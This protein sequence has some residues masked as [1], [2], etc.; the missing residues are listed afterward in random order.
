MSALNTSHV[1]ALW[2]GQHKG[3]EVD[4]GL[5]ACPTW[6]GVIPWGTIRMSWGTHHQRSIISISWR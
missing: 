2:Q 3:P 5:V 6:P 1:L 4:Y